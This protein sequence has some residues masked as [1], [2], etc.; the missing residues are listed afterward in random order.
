MKYELDYEYPQINITFKFQYTVGT[1]K[2]LPKIC[3]SIYQGADNVGQIRFDM[4]AYKN[5]RL[6]KSNKSYAWDTIKGEM[7]YQREVLTLIT[8]L[9]EQLFQQWI[10]SH[11]DLSATTKNFVENLAPENIQTLTENKQ[12]EITPATLFR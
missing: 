9:Q 1:N 5:W 12:Y 3:F 8:E 10:D 2:I 6:Y 4:E 11:I 7:P